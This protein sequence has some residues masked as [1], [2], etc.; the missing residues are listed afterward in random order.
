MKIN[1]KENVVLEILKNFPKNYN[2]NN[3]S[4]EIGLSSMGSLKILNILKEEGI[5]KLEK[6]SNIKF[7]SFDF[8]N[9]YARDYASLLFR[10]EAESS[11]P[12]VK[13][14]INEFGK[15]KYA[16][17]GILFG[18]ILTKGKNAKDVDVLFVVNKSNFDK[19][20]SEISELNKLNDKEIHAVYQTRNDFIKNLNLKDEVVLEI[21]KGILVFGEREFVEI[22]GEVK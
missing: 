5:F 19:L 16:E 14:W 2:A 6:V 1:N 9:S 8:D 22:I 10:K 3:L 7:Y 15:I 12:F 17:I 21:I 20:K 4:K 18:S 13:R 11:S